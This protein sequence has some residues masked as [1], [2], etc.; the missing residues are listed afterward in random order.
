[1]RQGDLI[2]PSLKGSIMFPSTSIKMSWLKT[3]MTIKNK[4]GDKASTCLNPLETWIDLFRDPLMMI[5]YFTFLTQPHM[6]IHHLYPN[7]SFASRHRLIQKVPIDMIISLFTI[8]FGYN[9]LFICSIVLN[10]FVGNKSLIE[11]C[12]PTIKSPCPS[13]IFE[14]NTFLEWFAR[15][16]ARIL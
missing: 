8:K 9:S 10:G 5:E 12:L 6:F 7:L 15:T 2:N 14:G 13:K 11:V 3:S 16:L 4:K 1:M